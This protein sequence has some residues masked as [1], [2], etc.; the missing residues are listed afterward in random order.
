MITN[1]PHLQKKRCSKKGLGRSIMRRITEIPET[2]S[3]QCSKEDK[4]VT[5]HSTAKSTALVRKNPQEYSGNTGKPKEESLKNRVFSLKKSHSTYDQVREQAE[6]PSSVQV[7]SREEAATENSTLESLSGKKRTQKLKE[8]EA[9]STES[10]PLVCKSA[11]A[12]NLSSEKQPGHPRTSMLQKSLSV[13]ASAKEKTLGLAGKTQTSGTEERA[14]SQKPLPREKEINKKYSNSESTETKDSASPNV[15]HAEEPRKPQKSGIIKQQRVNHPTGN[16]EMNPGTTQMKK[17]FDIGEVCPWEIYDLTP[18]PVPSESKVQKHVSIAASEMEKSPTSS[19]KEKSHQKPKTAELCQQSNQ[20]SIDK[21]AVCPWESQGQSLFKDEKHLISKTQ[22]T[23][24]RAENGNQHYAAS[25]CA[26]P[27]E[28]LTPKVV[29]ST[30]VNENL[31]QI[32]GQEKKTS[33]SEENVPGSYNSSKNFQQ[34]LTTRA[35]VCPWEFEIP[36]STKC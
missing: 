4:E 32:G 14:K 20:K 9:E 6:E 21:T 27:Y 22:A 36:R 11:S 17:N 31:N 3:R 33:S 8:S 2:V 19:L 28:G 10:V 12:H 35:E 16:T 5:D 29:A 24:G 23:P 18:G 1:N 15:N 34:P 13:I 25:V 7:G 30:V 26:G